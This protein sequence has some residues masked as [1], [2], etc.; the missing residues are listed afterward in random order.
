MG[1]ASSIS[2]GVSKTLNRKDLANPKKVKSLDGLYVN[3]KKGEAAGKEYLKKA[4][5]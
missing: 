2:R 1:T 4:S 3:M 5:K